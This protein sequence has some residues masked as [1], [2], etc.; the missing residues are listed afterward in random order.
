MWWNIGTG[1]SYRLS[2]NLNLAWQNLSW[3]RRELKKIKPEV[4]D[5][6][7][8]II[9]QYH[10]ESCFHAN[11][12]ARS[13]WLQAR[14]QPLRKKS[15]G[16]LIHVSDQW[17]GWLSCALGP[18]WQHSSWW[19]KNYLS[20]LQRSCRVH[21]WNEDVHIARNSYFWFNAPKLVISHWNEPLVTP[22]FPLSSMRDKGLAEYIFKMRTYSQKLLLPI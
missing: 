2:L 18:G 10:D 12:E 5:D 16:R 7:P 17:R 8:W 4:L 9:I 6:Q 22:S 15:R 21:I 19:T 14:E 1:F 3:M 11:D 20:R 13:L